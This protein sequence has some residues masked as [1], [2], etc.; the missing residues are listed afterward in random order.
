MT[1]NNAQ[2]SPSVDRKAEGAETP[3][4]SPLTGGEST[5]GIL[6]SVDRKESGLYNKSGF[7]L[8]VLLDAESMIYDA[9]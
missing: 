4:A 2:S 1:K 3:V 7:F 5:S 9:E 6:Q 8:S